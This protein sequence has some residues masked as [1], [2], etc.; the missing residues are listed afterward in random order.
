MTQP[1]SDAQPGGGMRRI[2]RK[3]TKGWRLP[4]GAVVVSRPSRWGN[5]WALGDPDPEWCGQS[6]ALTIKGIEV[7]P[8]DARGVRYHFDLYARD[9]LVRNP[10]WLYALRG[11]D[12]ACWCPTCP[13]HADGL[14][15]GETC[16]DCAPCHAT[17]LLELANR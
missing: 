10:G 5:P 12:L 16:A 13:K 6:I 15:L 9:Q 14:P 2:Q 3:R 1:D 8:L 17:V 11:H 7:R 4:A